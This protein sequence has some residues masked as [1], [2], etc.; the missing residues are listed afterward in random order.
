MSLPVERVQ[1]TL[2]EVASPDAGIP[3]LNCA[4]TDD[5]D[6]T[7]EERELRGVIYPCHPCYP[8]LTLPILR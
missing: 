4:P 2:S 1:L 8:W 3:P 7:D 6:N 5:T